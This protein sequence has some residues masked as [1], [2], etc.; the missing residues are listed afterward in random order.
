MENCIFCSIVDKKSPANI[1]FEDNNIIAFWSIEPKA[2]VHILIV[3]KKHIESVAKLEEI[4]A[5]L[6]GQMVLVAKGL[7]EKKDIAGNGYKL[8][9][10]VGTHGGQAVNHI[11]LH[12]I[13]GAQLE[14]IV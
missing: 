13:G 6:I 14:E 11:H 2:P 7:A 3:P 9:F 1:E 5:E 8:I 12:L 4:D 10:N